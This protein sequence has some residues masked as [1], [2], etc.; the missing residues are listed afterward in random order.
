MFKKIARAYLKIAETICVILLVIIMVCMCI[1]IACRLLTIGQNF[2]EELCRLCFSLMIFI[3][4][5]LCLAEGADIVVDMVVNALPPAVRRVTDF[6]SN[7]LIAFFS[8]LAIR[9]Q[10]NVIQ[11]NKGV[12]AVSMTWIKMNWLYTAFLISFVCLFIVAVCK[13]VA[14]LLGRS[15]TIDINA[16]AKAKAIQ[17]AKEMDI[18]L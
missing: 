3:G 6:I 14:A 5:P 11:T 18:G 1:Q 2:T 17:E 16:A 13:A 15:Q 9:S 7:A 10:W 8:V 12:T 4:A